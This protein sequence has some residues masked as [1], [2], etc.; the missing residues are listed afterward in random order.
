MENEDLVLSVKDQA[1]K[2]GES[3]Y[4]GKYI[5]ISNI[6]TRSGITLYA[7]TQFVDEYL[8]IHQP[9]LAH[10]EIKTQEQLEKAILYRNITRSDRTINCQ[11]GIWSRTAKKWLNYL[12]YKWKKVQKGVFYNR[13]E[14]DDIVEYKEKFLE[15]MKELLPYFVQFGEDGSILPKEYPKDCAVGRLNKRP[16]IMIK[17]DKNIFSANDGSRRV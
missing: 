5:P 11:A 14:Q 1:K 15:E 17:Y 10:D 2:T 16:I 6:N 12:G 7:F 8:C 13:H 4:F 9:K 3:K